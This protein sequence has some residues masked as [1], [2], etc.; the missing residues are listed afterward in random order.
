MK[1]EGLVKDLLAEKISGDALNLAAGYEW[2]I[3]KGEDL[4]ANTIEFVAKHYF[5][6]SDST[7]LTADYLDWFLQRQKDTL[8]LLVRIQSSGKVAGIISCNPSVVNARDTLVKG[9]DVKM[10]CV[11][12]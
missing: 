2:E 5:D 12:K 4:D 10:L 1:K 8:T 3:V 6:L 9:V 7:S 11:H